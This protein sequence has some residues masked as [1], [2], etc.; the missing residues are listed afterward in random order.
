MATRIWQTDFT[1]RLQQLFP[2]YCRVGSFRARIGAPR[3]IGSV[4]LD[5]RVFEFLCWRHKDDHWGF[6]GG[7][8]PAQGRT[9]GIKE[10][11]SAR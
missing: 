10:R 11:A 2:D 9:T 1:L 6:I 3:N 4:H 7:K 8:A 5:A